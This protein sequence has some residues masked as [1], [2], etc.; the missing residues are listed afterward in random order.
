MPKWLR[1]ALLCIFWWGVF[2]LLAKL[3]SDK[4]SPADMQVLFTGSML[5]LA[6]AAFVTGGN[7]I[8]T[9]RLGVTYGVLIGVLAGLGSLAFFAAMA[10]GKASIVGP[11]TSLFPLLTVILAVTVLKERMNRV[12]LAGIVL[13]LIAI[14]VLSV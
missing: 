11:V 13:A 10:H 2:G 4:I 12:Q 3:G 1:Y 5:P 9:D 8:D 6:V 14:A 7:K